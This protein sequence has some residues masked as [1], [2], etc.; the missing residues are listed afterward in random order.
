MS[1]LSKLYYFNSQKKKHLELCSDFSPHPSLTFSITIL[2]FYEKSSQVCLS[3]LAPA[4]SFLSEVQG[5]RSWI[6]TS[7]QRYREC[8]IAFPAVWQ[9]V[10]NVSPLLSEIQ[11]AQTP[12]SVSQLLIKVLQ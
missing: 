11:T 3:I 1:D 8:R 4:L 9:L 6:M 5:E 10:P 7:G 12:V 2:A